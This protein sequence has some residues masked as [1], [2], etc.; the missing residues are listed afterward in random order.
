MIFVGH[1]NYKY[2]YFYHFIILNKYYSITLMANNLFN[3]ECE[4]IVLHYKHLYAFKEK[5][6]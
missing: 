4:T 3:K 6:R 1:C 2:N 5:P